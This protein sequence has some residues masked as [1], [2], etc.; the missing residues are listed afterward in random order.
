MTSYQ[1]FM[2]ALSGQKPDQVPVMVFNRD[3]AM[4]QVGFTVNDMMNGVERFVFA[5]YHCA[6]EFGYDAVQDPH[7][8]SAESEAL[9]CTLRIEEG[10][11]LTVIDHPIRDYEKDLSG[12]KVLDPYRDGRLPSILEMVR[13]LKELCA[14]SFVVN[15]YIQAPFR[16]AAMLRGTDVY[17]DL[18]RNRDHLVQLLEKTLISQIAYGNAL[19]N[20]GADVLVISDPTSSGDVISRAYWLELGHEYVKKLVKYLRPTGV[21]IYLHICGDNNDRLETFADLDLDGISFGEKVDL[22]A[23]RN[24]LGDRTCIIGNVG[25]ANLLNS[26]PEAIADE[27]RMCIEKAGK[28]GSFIL[29]SGCSISKDCPPENIRAMVSTA[30]G[31][32]Y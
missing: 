12:L 6:I 26:S 14:G 22:E 19:V 5:Q 20:A 10:F 28:N 8:I 11:P 13:R 32:K 16:N 31:Y 4:Q 23:A 9:G 2:S 27:S 30:S 29:C 1:R 7:G 25:T 18:S 17:K 24:T 15:P 3:W 21:K